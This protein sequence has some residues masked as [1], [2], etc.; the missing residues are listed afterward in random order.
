MLATVTVHAAT[1]CD[2]KGLSVGDKAT[3]TQIMKHFGIDK[4]VEDSDAE[5]TKQQKAPGYWEHVKKVGLHNAAE[6]IFWRMGPSCN[7]NS[8]EIP[9]GVTV[10]SGAFPISVGVF[11]SFDKA[12]TIEAIDVTY[13]Y[14][15]WDEVMELLNTKYGNSC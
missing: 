5:F 9:F 6:E 11:I 13:D 4:F 10:G 7:Y 8:C 15:Q 2:F 3:P 1:P 14:L 12:G